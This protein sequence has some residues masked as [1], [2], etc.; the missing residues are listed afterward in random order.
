MRGS[1]DLGQGKPGDGLGYLSGESDE[2]G[3]LI[4]CE[5]RGNR[6]QC[7]FSSLWVGHVG[8]CRGHFLRLEWWRR[9]K[10]GVREDRRFS[11]RYNEPEN[12]SFLMTR[13]FSAL[14]IHLGLIHRTV[15]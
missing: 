6:S 5:G 7:R 11:L 15:S 1:D 4:G 13:M 8:R 9:S 2:L 14:L 10:K 3:D 12:A